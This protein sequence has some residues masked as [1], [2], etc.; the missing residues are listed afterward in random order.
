MSDLFLRMTN[1]QNDIPNFS[2]WDA[3]GGTYSNV[4][5]TEKIFPSMYDGS[6]TRGHAE[7]RCV[8]IVNPNDHKVDNVKVKMVSAQSFI[9]EA[10]K[11]F[12][13][14]RPAAVEAPANSNRPPMGHLLNIDSG[15]IVFYTRLNVAKQD[16]LTILPKHRGMFDT[17]SQEIAEGDRLQFLAPLRI[18]VKQPPIG[19]IKQ[20]RQIPHNVRFSLPHEAATTCIEPYS[21]VGVWIVRSYPRS[22]DKFCTERFRID[23][24]LQV[25]YD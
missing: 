11:P 25:T 4:P 8:A 1:S 9:V 16:V 12:A 15:E 18:A 22:I 24:S 5:V 10:T 13:K 7:Y 2:G 3:K 23:A 20:Y 21:H 6:L 19:S 14:Y 17:Q